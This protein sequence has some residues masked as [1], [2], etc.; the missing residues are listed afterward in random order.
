MGGDI[1]Y[2][3]PRKP[4]RPGN[5]T[6]GYTMGYRAMVASSRTPAAKPIEVDEPPPSAT[7]EEAAGPVVPLTGPAAPRPAGADAGA[8]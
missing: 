2:R 4:W 3:L 6:A 5:Q 1:L 7:A 8:D